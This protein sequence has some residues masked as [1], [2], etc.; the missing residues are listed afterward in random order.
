[1]DRRGANRAQIAF[2]KPICGTNDLQE[3]TLFLVLESW[4]TL[5]MALRL[6]DIAQDLGVSL[7]TVSKALRNHPD[8]RNRSA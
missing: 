3:T 5:N 1:M 8:I 7:M 2:P 6:K 4:N